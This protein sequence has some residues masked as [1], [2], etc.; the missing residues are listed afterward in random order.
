MLT[1]GLM[2]CCVTITR[3]NIAA[4]MVLEALLI[5]ILIVV[6]AACFLDQTP[7]HRVDKRSVGANAKQYITV[8]SDENG[9]GPEMTAIC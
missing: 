8:S 9:H 2:T 5:V 1:A 3:R 4:V 7:H 6:C